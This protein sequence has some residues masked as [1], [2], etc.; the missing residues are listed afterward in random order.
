M[1]RVEA[2]FQAGYWHV[3]RKE[4]VDSIHPILD[5]VPA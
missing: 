4:V 5:E 2:F 3:H 1:Y